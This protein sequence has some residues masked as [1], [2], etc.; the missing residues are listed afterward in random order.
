MASILIVD[1]D[2]DA[3]EVAAARLRIDGHKVHCQTNGRDALLQ[4]IERTPDAVVLDLLMPQ[5]DGVNL[6]DVIRSYLRLQV[7]PVVVWTGLAEDSPLVERAQRY[8]VNSVIVKGKASL[9]DLSVA[10]QEAIKN[11]PA[12]PGSIP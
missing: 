7:L 3:C 11:P 10:V 12:Q 2:H 9:D 6:L 4:L 1:D 8:R 5:L